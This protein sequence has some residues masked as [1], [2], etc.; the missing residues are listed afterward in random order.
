MTSG[1]APIRASRR[2][3]LFAACLAL[4]WACSM[5]VSAARC[6]GQQ[7]S[8][9][10]AEGVPLAA[11]AR[12]ACDLQHACD[13]WEIHVAAT[14]VLTLCA[15]CFCRWLMLSPGPLRLVLQSPNRQ[16]QNHLLLQNLQ[17]L[18]RLLA[19]ARHPALARHPPLPLQSALAQAGVGVQRCTLRRMQSFGCKGRRHLACSHPC[20]HL[21]DRV[22]LQPCGKRRG[23]HHR[24]DV[25]Q[26][27]VQLQRNMWPAGRQPLHGRHWEPVGRRMC[28]RAVQ[29][30]VQ[31]LRLQ[32]RQAGGRRACVTVTPL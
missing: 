4:A 11:A 24:C 2:R 28:Q 25:P 29:L 30:R 15:C 6:G 20:L 27:R 14:S 18:G 10:W 19:R 8:W 13:R 23:V 22:L 16:N 1:P 12:H 3:L 7:G 17:N 21:L 32:M 9:G 26:R 5:P 31:P